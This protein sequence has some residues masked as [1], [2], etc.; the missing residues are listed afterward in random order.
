MGELDAVM[1]SLG[2][3]L[4]RVFAGSSGDPEP[5]R[6]ANAQVPLDHMRDTAPAGDYA[7]AHQYLLRA[8]RLKRR[9][10]SLHFY[11]SE[12]GTREIDIDLMLPLCD[13][14]PGVWF[15]PIAFFPKKGVA[16]AL[17]VRDGTGTLL[18]IPTKGENMGLTERAI[19]ALA[20]NGQLDLGNSSRR[21]E[22]I[23]EII[24][25][26]SLDA[27]VCRLVFENHTDE[28]SA[29][30]IALLQL[31]EDQFLLW[32]PISG[33]P[34]SRHH[35]SIR[36]REFR[37]KDPI[38]TRKRRARTYSVETALG[39]VKVGVLEPSGRPTVD[40]SVAL[41][42]T[43]NAFA[44]RPIEFRIFDSEA[45]RFASSHLRLL[46]PAGF[47][48]RNVRAAAFERGQDR[49]QTHLEEFSNSGSHAV[50]QGLDQTI[51]HVHLSE[52]NNPANVYSRVTLGLRGGMTTLWMLAAVLTAVLLWL[53]HHHAGYGSPDEQNKQITAAA[54]LVGPAFAS[55]WSLRA[56]NGELLRTFLAG[57]RGLLLASAALSVATALALA[58]VMPSGTNR[59]DAIELYASA[60]YFVAVPLLVA[61]ILA[62][63]P[64]WLI[65]RDWLSTEMRNLLAILLMS[66][67]I[68]LVGL[69]S[70]VPFRLSGLLLLGTG[71]ALSVIAA[72]SAAEPLMSARTMYRPLAGIG[73]LPAILL[74]GFYLGFYSDQ[75]TGP[76][77]RLAC[78]VSGG[79]LALAAIWGLVRQS[80]EA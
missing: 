72:N 73:L 75:M 29:E 58:E 66:A 65:L 45:A 27:R 6:S 69:H 19:T 62:S 11:F 61:W 50:V 79:V 37:E 3:K 53:V 5:V 13:E 42:L 20:D 12:V 24:C 80:V 52:E 35:V 54:L 34:G 49:G 71:V 32:A 47:I 16:P 17:E 55:A 40:L 14:A 57:A 60:S 70:G 43:L 4:R 74:A 41:E 21:R 18:A 38:L 2:D 46:A 76:T 64:T 33:A 48:V 7:I 59:Y 23:R 1:T 30:L 22:L 63:R 51:A 36:R 56:D 26:E 44:L 78:T 15:V 28:P 25:L 68:L 9:E 8:S 77:A 67:I 10:S 31:L 39:D